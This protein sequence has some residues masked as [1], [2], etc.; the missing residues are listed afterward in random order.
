MPSSFSAYA[1]R[2]R[3]QACSFV[4][5]L[6]LRQ[7]EV[8]PAA[9]LEQ[10][11]RVVEEG[12]TEV[13]QA[14]PRWARGRLAWRSGRCQPR[15]RIFSV[16]LPSVQAVRLL[17][18]SS[19]IVRRTPRPSRLLSLDDVLPRRR[20]GVLEVRHEDPCAR[21][22]RVDHHL[23][24]DRAGDLAAA[25][26]QVGRCRRDLPVASAILR[27]R[28]EGPG[29][30]PRRARAAAP[31]AVL[32][33]LLALPIQLAVEALDERERLL[34]QDRLDR[35]LRYRDARASVLYATASG[36]RTAPLRSSP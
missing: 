8:R 29:S 35:G 22:E 7:V 31:A 10:L 15:G 19:A 21:V 17:G 27:L 9:A 34:R 6:E 13:E 20:A 2:S 3:L 36:A 26:L 14:A 5:R 16:A 33:Q 24:L 32:Q 23:P 25:V 18:V 30:R 28:E 4:V 12:E 1:N 11:L